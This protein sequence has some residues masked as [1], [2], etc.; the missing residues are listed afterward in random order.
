M[1]QTVGDQAMFFRM[2][3]S[4]LQGMCATNV[5][6]TLHARNKVYEEIKEMTT[7]RFK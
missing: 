4:K 6:D 2:L 5:D 1:K 3:D 7:K